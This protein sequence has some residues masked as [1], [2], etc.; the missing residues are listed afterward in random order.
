MIPHG[1]PAGFTAGCRTVHCPAPLP[2]RD[3]RRRYSGDWRFRKLVDSGLPLEEIL[4]SEVEEAARLKAERRE[5][6]RRSRPK[7][8]T[9]SKPSRAASQVN[10]LHRAVTELLAQGLT[11]LQVGERIGRTRIQ[12]RSIRRHLGLPINAVQFDLPERL[13]ALH[14]EGLTDTQIA[15]RLGKDRGHVSRVRRNMKLARN[16]HLNISPAHVKDR[17][18][19]GLTDSQIAAELGVERSGVAKYRRRLGLAPNPAQNSKEIM[20]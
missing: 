4:A 13:R 18:S 19:A 16:V 11:D 10:E 12:V 20:K 3:V 14:A 2:C 9:A 17:H 15:E 6:A 1:T 5:E 8:T 7:R